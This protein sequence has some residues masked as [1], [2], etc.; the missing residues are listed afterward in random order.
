MGAESCYAPPFH[1]IAERINIKQAA[2]KAIFLRLHYY[3]NDKNLQIPVMKGSGLN[4]KLT[5]SSKPQALPQVGAHLILIF[6]FGFV[7]YILVGSA[8]NVKKFGKEANKEAL[9]H[10]EFW[11]SIPGYVKE[12]MRFTAFKLCGKQMLGANYESL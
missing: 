9:P 12:G 3:N 10:R 11:M 4:M 1:V 6:G 7:G 8:I 2:G 5:Y